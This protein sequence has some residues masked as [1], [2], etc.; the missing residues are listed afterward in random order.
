MPRLENLSAEEL[1]QIKWFVEETD[2]DEP[3]D[4]MRALVET[5]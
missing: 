2:V 3:S 4:E 5:H 1:E